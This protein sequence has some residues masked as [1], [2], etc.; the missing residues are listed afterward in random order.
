MTYLVRIAEDGPQILF[1][2]NCLSLVRL[3][4]THVK[5]H[6]GLESHILREGLS[7]SCLQKRYPLEQ[8]AKHKENKI[9]L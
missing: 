5:N 3:H 9:P 2:K 7:E 6:H 8:Q 1:Q 4:E